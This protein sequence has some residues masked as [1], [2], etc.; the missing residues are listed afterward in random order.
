MGSQDNCLLPDEA[1]TEDGVK[2]IFMRFQETE[3]AHMRGRSA[4]R[5]GYT[6]AVNSTSTISVFVLDVPSL[7]EVEKV[8]ASLTRAGSSRELLMDECPSTMFPL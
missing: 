6:A 3:A 2:G 4:A 1:T 7:L 8:R 5:L